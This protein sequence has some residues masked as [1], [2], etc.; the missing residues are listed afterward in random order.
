[1][2]STVLARRI[3]QVTS[4]PNARPIIT[5]FTT[6]SAAMNMPNGDRSCGSIEAPV[7]DTVIFGAAGAD[8]GTDR[9]GALGVAVEVAAGTALDDGPIGA[10]CVV[11]AGEAVWAMTSGA[12]P[13]RQ[14]TNAIG[15]ITL[16]S[17][18]KSGNPAR[19]K[20]T[21]TFALKKENTNVVVSDPTFVG[22]F[23]IA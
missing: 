11:A 18:G 23:M 10:A 14:A 12:D 19:F 1:M 16:Q 3:V 15:K 6:M 20:V 13:A 22:V 17:A 7:P 5:A 4:E 8:S 21:Q 2:S 9:A